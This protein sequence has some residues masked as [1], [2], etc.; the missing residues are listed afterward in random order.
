MFWQETY[1][2]NRRIGLIFKLVDTGMR[3][4]VHTLDRNQYTGVAFSTYNS[5]AHLPGFVAAGGFGPV[6]T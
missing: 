2:A 1:V 6:N 4:L 5:E 3:E